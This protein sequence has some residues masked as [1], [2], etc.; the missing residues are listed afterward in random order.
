ME[1]ALLVTPARP[2][3]AIWEPAASFANIA[4]PDFL[5]ALRQGQMKGNRTPVDLDRRTYLKRK[6]SAPQGK[7]SQMKFYRCV[8]QPTQR[9]SGVP[10]VERHSK[11]VHDSSVR[12]PENLGKP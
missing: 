1:M 6:T 5:T 3:S 8:A 4:L 9:L 2:G 7:R 10:G 11:L 12:N